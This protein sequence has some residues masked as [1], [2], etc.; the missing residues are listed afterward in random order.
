MILMRIENF[1]FE[2]CKFSA[3]IEIINRSKIVYNSNKLDQ[4]RNIDLSKMKYSKYRNIW[5]FNK[6]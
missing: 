5:G 2:I 3:Y 4:E 1:E 6:K